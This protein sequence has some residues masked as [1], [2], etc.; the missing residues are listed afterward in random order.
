MAKDITR[1][2]TREVE[3][4]LWARN[5]GRCQFNGCNRLLYKSPVT[6]Q[7]ANISEKAHIYS[8]AK[9]GPRGWGP[10]VTNKKAL[11]HISNLML[12][13]HDCHELIDQEKDGGRYPAALLIKWKDE[14]EKRVAINT[15][16]D[17]SKKSHV[18][19]YGANIGD[20]TS[21]LQPEHC[22]EALFPRMNPT[23][24]RP[25]YLSM[26][27]ERQDD[28]EDYWATE[29]QNI[30]TSFTRQIRPLID[31][32]DPLHFS[33]FA[34]A[35]Q[36]LLIYLGSLFTDKIPVEVYQLHRE[37][38][39]TWHWLEGPP[40]SEYIIKPPD[41]F[42]NPPTLII[43]L[44][45]PISHERIQAVIGKDVSIWELTIANPNNDFLKSKGQL[46]R[47]RETVRKLMVEI[48]KAH[49]KAATLS[50]FPAMP[51]ACAVELGR[52]RMPKA[53]IPWIIY[54]QNHK[55][56]KFIKTLTIGDHHE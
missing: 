10:F 28:H 5:A 55:H 50:I 15:G 8:F 7:Q 37:P 44:S 2:I 53:D 33:I 16:I 11:N 56:N 3:R 23:D 47:Y 32:A 34:L 24:E 25:I 14:H 17:P 31:M 48:G 22:K 12:V 38:H 4:E 52:V 43:S 39:P 26:T 20:E 21:K 40:D 27:W 41:E 54:D 13:C 49:G 18:I 51:V 42:A 46:S 35:P 36:P 29:M 9:N 30:E 19:L 45:A 6:Q 1:Y